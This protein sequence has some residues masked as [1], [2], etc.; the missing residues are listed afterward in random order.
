[1]L[2]ARDYF[3][4]FVAPEQLNKSYQAAFQERDLSQLPN[5][6]PNGVPSFSTQEDAFKKAVNHAPNRSNDILIEH[7]I[8]N[9][10]KLAPAKLKS[11][12]EGMFV[13][14]VKDLIANAAAQHSR[15]NY[16]G[17][18]IFFNVGL[19]DACYQYAILY[20]EFIRLVDEGKRRGDR[21]PEIVQLTK[22]VTE[23]TI[24]I[25]IAQRR[26]NREGLVQ[27]TW[28]DVVYSRPAMEGYAITIAT[29]SDKF[30]LYHEIAHHILGHTKLGNSPFTF[31][32][33]LPD[34]CKYWRNTMSKKHM[35][36]YEA[37]AAALLMTLQTRSS[38]LQEERD[39]EL[40]IAVGGLLTLTIIGQFARHVDKA[41][42]DHPSVSS[43]FDQCVAILKESCTYETSIG[44]IIDDIKRF[45]ILLRKS[46]GW[47]LGCR[48]DMAEFT[49][50]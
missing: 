49:H 46:Q 15:G 11:R 17:D 31:L 29:Y 19:S 8:E 23:H 9:L 6:L 34:I 18:L 42:I 41:S 20:Y 2:T 10:I 38:N 50:N 27:F 39:K 40:S 30:I 26:W 5:G 28:D 3:Y 21:H 36:E 14:K 16:D 45:Q 47:G 24:K 37:D 48:W 35:Q 43:R 25:A 33:N 12:L 1:M 4:K 7:Y 44:E 22:S 32:E 13:A